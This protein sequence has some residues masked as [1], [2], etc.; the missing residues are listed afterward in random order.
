[1]N[2]GA[3]VKDAQQRLGHASAMTTLDIYAHATSEDG[4]KFSDAV[5]GAFSSV[6]NLLAEGNS[7]PTTGEMLN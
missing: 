1:V 5:E 3:Q 4:R 2:S 7:E 6:G